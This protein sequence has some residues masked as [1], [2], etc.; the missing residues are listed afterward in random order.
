MAGIL[1]AVRVD[2]S[3]TT[4]PFN[5]LYW[6]NQSDCY[7]NGSQITLASRNGTSTV[8]LAL[9]QQV[10][11]ISNQFPQF[12]TKCESCCRTSEYSP[13]WQIPQYVRTSPE[14]ARGRED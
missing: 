9:G 2:T 13:E 10:S 6:A 5:V 3:I 14:I 4:R 1:V 8:V 11:K 12:R 7:A